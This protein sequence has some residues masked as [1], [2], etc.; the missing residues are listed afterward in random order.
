MRKLLAMGVLGG[1]ANSLLSGT[2]TTSPCIYKETTTR[3]LTSHWRNEK[4]ADK[5]IKASV[6]KNHELRQ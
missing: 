2:T 1:A 6:V 5:V 3:G 4:D